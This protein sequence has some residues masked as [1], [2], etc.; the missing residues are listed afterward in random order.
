MQGQK[1]AM[2]VNEKDLEELRRIQ[3]RWR[4]TRSRFND[5]KTNMQFPSSIGDWL[6]KFITVLD[7]RLEIIE[8][9]LIDK[10]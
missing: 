9:N 5:L 1:G 3:F 7:K 4:E 2:T 10:D 6:E 8:R